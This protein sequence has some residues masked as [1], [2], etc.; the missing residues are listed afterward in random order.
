MGLNFVKYDIWIQR[1]G[2]TLSGDQVLLKYLS[3]S[4]LSSVVKDACD[5]MFEDLHEK[6]GEKVG[7]IDVILW[8]SCQKGLIKIFDGKV[9]LDI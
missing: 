3:K 8:R 1:L 9:F 2:V 5:K 7:F 4:K 6:T